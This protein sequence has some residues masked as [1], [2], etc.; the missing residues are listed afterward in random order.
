MQLTVAEIGFCHSPK[1][2]PTLRTTSTPSPLGFSL[3]IE[4]QFQFRQP[5]KL[6]HPSPVPPLVAKYKTQRFVKI[7]FRF[8][9]A[10]IKILCFKKLSRRFIYFFIIEDV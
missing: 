1:F 10:E 7:L 4:E 3:E 9:A 8:I 6:Q 2:W 5:T